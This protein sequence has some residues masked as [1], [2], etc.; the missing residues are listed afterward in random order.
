LID[1]VGGFRQ[2]LMETAK[3]A[4]ISGEPD[5]VRPSKNK[6]GLFSLMMDDGEDLFANPGQ[7]LNRSP[8]FYF[9]WK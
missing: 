3:E 8:G 9:M 5:V 4:G 7:L 2:A 1:K 6:R